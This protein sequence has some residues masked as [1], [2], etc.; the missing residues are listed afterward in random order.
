VLCPLDLDT[1]YFPQ[2][3]KK[4]ISERETA[5][6]RVL[7][8]QE[9]VAP[10]EFVPS[11]ERELEMAKK[12]KDELDVAKVALPKSIET[13]KAMLTTLEAAKAKADKAA[14][15]AQVKFQQ[16]TDAAAKATAENKEALQKAV[17]AAKTELSAAEP[18]KKDTDAKVAAQQ[19][20]VAE[21]T[22]EY[23]AID[24]ALVS[25]T[26]RTA[27]INK[28]IARAAE[29]KVPGQTASQ[30]AAIA[31]ATCITLRNQLQEELIARSSMMCHKHLSDVRAT[32][33]IFN[34]TVGFA[35]LAQS[36]LAAIVT[37]QTWARVLAAGAS[38]ATGTQAIGNKEI[39][40]DFVVP[41][42]TRAINGER[43]RQLG[44]LRV[45][46][47]RPLTQYP[48]GHALGD[49][50]TYHEACS[51]SSGLELIGKDADR[52]V[53]QSIPDL[54]VRL[55]ALADQIKAIDASITT[56]SD[57]AEKRSAERSK[58]RLRQ[59]MEIL[60]VRIASARQGG[61]N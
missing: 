39:Y 7:A 11:L 26:D 50:A 25:N 34:A 55:K 51:F 31:E 1:Y 8:C 42:I 35:S 10:L 38:V 18:L 3:L 29:A 37:G 22:A 4:P 13:E 5:Y 45:N 54:E 46:R 47:L 19:K 17:G 57:D 36:S 53:E 43:D 2:D 12:R 56:S 28:Q 61:T 33:A 41:A 49:A 44:L 30:E 21:L 59:E 40:R 23:S 9:K 6:E 16:A 52:R 48:V 27:E 32:A 14:A 60:Q 24:A 58:L 20:K 15:D